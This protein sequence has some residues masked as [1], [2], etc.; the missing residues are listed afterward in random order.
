ME[1]F[2]TYPELRELGI[3]YSREHIRRLEVRGL[4]PLHTNLDENGKRIGWEKTLIHERQKRKAAIAQENAKVARAEFK[5]RAKA[6]KAQKE[7]AA[8]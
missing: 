7:R 5:R 3:T 6:A 8:P 2:Y 1:D 4:F